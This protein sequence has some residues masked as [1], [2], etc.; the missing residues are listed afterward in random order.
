MVSISGERSFEFEKETTFTQEPKPSDYIDVY[1]VLNENKDLFSTDD[2]NI[3]LDREVTTSTEN[4]NT[5]YTMYENVKITENNKPDYDPWEPSSN[6]E[7]PLSK[8]TQSN[9]TLWEIH[10]KD[11]N[12]VISRMTHGL[13][14]PFNKLPY[15]QDRVC[16]GHDVINCIVKD[17]D[18]RKRARMESENA[19]KV[20]SQL[21]EYRDFT[22]SSIGLKD[23]NHKFRF[24]FRVFHVNNHKSCETFKLNLHP[25]IHKIK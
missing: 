23:K 12:R 16:L 4:E 14:N 25:V 22:S 19:I 2:L 24:I 11:I 7:P 15:T 8:G 10:A 18:K 1:E 6:D 5:T 9:K 20:Y 3:T 13:L 21:K 17:K